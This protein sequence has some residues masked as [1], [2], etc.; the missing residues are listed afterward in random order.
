MGDTVNLPDGFDPASFRLLHQ[1]AELVSKTAAPALDA[2][3]TARNSVSASRLQ[4]FSVFEASS[5]NFILPAS[6]AIL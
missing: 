4:I 2:L 5:C 3:S 6:T 1:T